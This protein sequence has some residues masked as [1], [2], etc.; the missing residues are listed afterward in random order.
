VINPGGTD[1]GWM[2]DEIKAKVVD[3]TLGGRL[4]TP[5]DCANLVSFVCSEA[6]GWV[7]GQLL[8]SDGGL[9]RG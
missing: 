5:Q 3:Q 4:G 1:T 8:Y 7:N 9:S 2:S 6:G